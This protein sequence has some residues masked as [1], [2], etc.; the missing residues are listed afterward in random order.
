MAD[1]AGSGEAETAPRVSGR[2][3]TLPSIT[4][5]ERQWQAAFWPIVTT[6]RAG[7]KL[8]HGAPALRLAVREPVTQ[9]KGV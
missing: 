8:A 3:D 2:T 5:S 4:K 7:A 9:L 6:L 1:V